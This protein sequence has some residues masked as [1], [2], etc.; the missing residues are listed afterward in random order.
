V[1]KFKKRCFIL[2]VLWWK[3]CGFAIRGLTHLQNF[4]ICDLQ[5]NQNKYADMKFA[6]SHI[7]EICGFAIANRA[8]EFADLGFCELKKQ[9]CKFATSV[10]DTSCAANFLALLNLLKGKV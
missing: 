3:I 1:R 2:S 8:Q 4:Q 5:I 10:N 6:N 9:L 7:S